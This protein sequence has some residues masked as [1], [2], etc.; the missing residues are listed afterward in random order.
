MLNTKKVAYLLSSCVLG[1]LLINPILAEAGPKPIVRPTIVP[2]ALTPPVMPAQHYGP[3]ISGQTGGSP[4]QHDSSSDS[5]WADALFPSE[6]AGGDGKEAQDS[7]TDVA[8]KAEVDLKKAEE[9]TDYNYEGTQ[10]ALD[11]FGRQ[12]SP[13][14]ISFEVSEEDVL[15]NDIGGS[16][17]GSADSERQ[18]TSSQNGANTQN[19]DLEGS[20]ASSESQS[21]PA[22][23]DNKTGWLPNPFNWFG[24]KGGKSQQDSGTSGVSSDDSRQEVEAPVDPIPEGNDSNPQ[25]AIDAANTASEAE[26]AGGEI[27]PINGTPAKEMD[28]PEFEAEDAQEARALFSEE[29]D[30]QGMAVGGDF[31]EV[32]SSRQPSKDEFL[33][34]SDSLGL[35]RSTTQIINNRISD[36]ST[37]FALVSAGQGPDMCLNSTWVSG[38][39]GSDYYKGSSKARSNFTG[40]AIGADFFISETDLV[41]FALTKIYN[42]NGSKLVRASTSADVASVYSLLRFNNIIVSGSAFVGQSNTKNRRSNAAASF[43]TAKF[44]SLLYGAEASVGYQM[45][46]GNHVFTPYLGLAYSGASQRGYKEKGQGTLFSVKKAR[47]SVM[48]STLALKYN[49][50]IQKGDGYLIPKFT[51][52]FSKDIIDKPISISARSL[53]TQD[54]FSL[55]GPSATS[56]NSFF[57]APGL[58]ARNEYVDVDLSY[59]LER[60]MNHT[61]HLGLL[62]VS[63]K[64]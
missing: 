29:T 63:V 36:L 46:K 26:L 22:V 41:G 1:G 8:K 15:V 28:V 4:L 9:K 33:L 52:G 14:G 50:L 30:S 23:A 48:N 35:M 2:S 37:N 39:V 12:L 11:E 47:G 51:V 45:K 42:K 58:V 6:S 57:A 3:N 13:G 31:A 19:E 38:F 49:Y 62:K 55:K 10:A 17:G 25:S 60:S 18:E 16:V 64:F 32:N 5:T 54:S 61:S 44:K 53:G 34:K 7:T 40:G 20:D 56:Q 27:S 43:A 59:R 21:T 24:D